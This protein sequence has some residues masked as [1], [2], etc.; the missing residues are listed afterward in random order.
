M[1]RKLS[2]GVH[3]IRIKKPGGGTRAQR[4]NVLKSGKFK[5]I[6]N[7]KG[8]ARPKAKK[9]AAK[10]RGK[11][12]RTSPGR[13]KPGMARKKSSLGNRIINFGLFLLAFSQPIR[14]AFSSVGAAEKIGVL[15]RQA[16]FGLVRTLGG[17]SKFDLNEGLQFYGPVAAAFALFEVKKM[18][19]KKFRF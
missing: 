6:K 12:A 4:V 2:P 13:R 7:V 14:I 5:F 17:R 8:G 3:T 9:A 1:A 16:T 15:T 19:M 11:K 18:A 10:P